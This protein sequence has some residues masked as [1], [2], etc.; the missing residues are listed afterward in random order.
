MKILFSLTALCVL[1]C[2]NRLTAQDDGLQ[3]WGVPHAGLYIRSFFGMSLEVGVRGGIDIYRDVAGVT[4]ETGIM[5]GFGPP[6]VAVRWW[7]SIRLD[8]APFAGSLQPLYAAVGYGRLGTTGGGLCMA[9]GW[10]WPLRQEDET[11]DK[12]SNAFEVFVTGL[13][14]NGTTRYLPVP[15]YSLKLMPW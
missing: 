4:G 8:V 3:R 12:G 14:R 6:P 1:F 9:A 10:R 11:T 15:G 5:L 13:S 2:T 7:R